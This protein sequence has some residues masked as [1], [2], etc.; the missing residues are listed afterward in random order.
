M[1]TA[2]AIVIECGN[3]VEKELVLRIPRTIGE[4]WDMFVRLGQHPV[5]ITLA[6]G[7]SVARVS[8]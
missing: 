8:F 7:A 4:L 6:S 1:Q 3:H 5:S 2:S